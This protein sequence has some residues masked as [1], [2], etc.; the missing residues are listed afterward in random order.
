MARSRSEMA[1]KGR[2]ALADKA[3]GLKASWE[4]ARPRMKAGYASLD[5]GPRRK[6][7]YAAGIDR[8]V[9]N[10]PDPAKW[11]ANWTAKMGE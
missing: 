6:A 10:A 4:A 8:A 7:A 2:A 9:Y 5:F 1:A 3:S 11:E